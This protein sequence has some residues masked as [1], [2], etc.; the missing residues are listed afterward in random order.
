MDISSGVVRVRAALRVEAAGA[1]LY[2]PELIVIS[3]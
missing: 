1:V 2:C 3:P